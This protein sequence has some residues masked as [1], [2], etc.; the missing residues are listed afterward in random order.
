[1]KIKVPHRKWRRSR[2]G[3]STLVETL[4]YKNAMKLLSKLEIKEFTHTIVDEFDIYDWIEV[5]TW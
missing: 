2:S 1:M 3:L 4:Q 5:I